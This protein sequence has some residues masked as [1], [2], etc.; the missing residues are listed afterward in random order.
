MRPSG[1]DYRKLLAILKA[2]EEKYPPGEYTHHNLSY[3]RDG[4]PPRT[5]RISC[6]STSQLVAFST[7]LAIEEGNLDKP[8][9]QTLAETERALAWM[10]T[11]PPDVSYRIQGR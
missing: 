5:T 6:C 4:A 9:D 10:K 8:I 11:R 2:L 3:R 7:P 1:H